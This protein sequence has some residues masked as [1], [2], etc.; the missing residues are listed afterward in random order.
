MSLDS[1][2]AQI[3]IQ[4]SITPFDVYIFFGVLVSVGI[5]AIMG[6]S[7]IYSIFFGSVLGIGI[8]VLFSTILSPELQTPETLSIISE[9]FAKALIG[10]SVYLIF[11]LAVLVPINGGVSLSLPKTALGKMFQTIVISSVLILFLTAI[12]L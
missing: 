6:L 2:V 12:F 3:S 10:S 4:L 9:A 5:M 7:K 11:I 1:I 8:F